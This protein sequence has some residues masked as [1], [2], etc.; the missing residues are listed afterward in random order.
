MACNTFADSWW[1][2]GDSVALAFENVVKATHLN[3]TK[4]LTAMIGAQM[5]LQSSIFGRLGNAIPAAWLTIIP[6][7][8]RLPR[9]D[10]TGLVL[11]RDVPRVLRRSI[12]S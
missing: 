11:Q 3:I 12:S 8:G 5:A 2:Q 9:C 4:G 1:P 6:N 10:A 7:Y